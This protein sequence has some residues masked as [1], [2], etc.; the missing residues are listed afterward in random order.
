MTQYDFFTA[1]YVK[2]TVSSLRDYSDCMIEIFL[3]L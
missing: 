1:K 2:E 3:I